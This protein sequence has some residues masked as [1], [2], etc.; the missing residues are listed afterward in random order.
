VILNYSKRDIHL[1]PNSHFRDPFDYSY[2]GIELYYIDG[3]IEVGSVAKG[4]PAEL[5][6][7]KEGDVVIAVNNDFS[8]N[9]N[10]YKSTILGA[11]SKVKLVVQ[12]KGELHQVD[13]KVKSIF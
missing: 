12:R 10:K 11:T 4:S 6:G 3:K 5:A 8:Q 2:S 9:F 13:L 1:T 7:I